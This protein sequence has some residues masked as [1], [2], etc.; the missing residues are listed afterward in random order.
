MIFNRSLV[1]L[2]RMLC[3][4]GPEGS[5]T[6]QEAQQTSDSSNILWL[7][8]CFSCNADSRSLCSIWTYS[9]ATRCPI[10][11]TC[12]LKN[13]HFLG[14]K[15]GFNTLMSTRGHKLLSTGD[16]YVEVDYRIHLR[17]RGFCTYSFTSLF[18]GL[19]IGLWC[20]WTCASL[21]SLILSCRFGIQPVSV[22]YLVKTFNSSNDIFLF[23]Q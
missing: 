19:E 22:S 6:A 8:L 10:S 13:S 20:F 14:C 3:K 21:A 12:R 17:P 4:L 9:L 2:I 16:E 15:F 1:N 23:W 7:P 11:L 18:K 5:P